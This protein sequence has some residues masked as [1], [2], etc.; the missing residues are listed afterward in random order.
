[1]IATCIGQG[2]RGLGRGGEG[3]LEIAIEESYGG[4][5][6]DIRLRPSS[7]GARWICAA[8]AVGLFFGLAIPGWAQTGDP[9]AAYRRG[10]FAAAARA[11]EPLA[12]RGDA[13][14][15]Y[16]LAVLYDL[17]QGVAR[18]LQAAAAW[19]RQA[20]EQGVSE[21]QFN[22]GAMYANGEGVAEDLV[23]A[24]AFLALAAAQGHADAASQRETVA[25]YLT[26]E[27]IAAARRLAKAVQASAVPQRSGEKTVE[28][29]I[30]PSG[31]GSGRRDTVA[32]RLVDDRRDPIF[33]NPD[34]NVTVVEFFDYRCPYC[35]TVAARLL[36]TV[37]RDG[38]IRLVFKELPVLGARSEYAARAALAAKNQGRYLAFHK[39]LMRSSGRLT[40]KRVLSIAK[41][42][43]VN[44]NRLRADMQS[45]EIDDAI[46]ANRDM[47]R[48]LGIRG[49]PTFV[50]A[51]R[52]VRGAV[53][54]ASIR[55]HVAK[56]R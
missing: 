26:R 12:R 8:L 15:Q 14:A 49:T 30:E 56:A 11:F 55:K 7:T 25:G 36:A 45:P 32:D 22:L 38:N 35:K 17:G 51:D 47:A 28:D 31:G 20:A 40:Q 19:Y 6:G 4:V 3:G 9:Y 46:A 52:T 13:D 42:V 29:R 54:M 24:Y 39:A 23:L 50:I 27:Q 1:M 18:D 2:D 34:G 10:D 21:A 44:T 53:S 48:K 33:G 43:G 37:K 41:S 16:S 5:P